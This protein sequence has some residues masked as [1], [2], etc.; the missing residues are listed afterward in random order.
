MQEKIGN[1]IKRGE[2]RPCDTELIAYLLF[3]AYF[4]LVAD[5]GKTHTEDL[6]EE[7]IV[8]VLSE[9]IFKSLLV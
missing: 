8:K 7:R 4:A 1:A 3:K 2:L 5:W 9:T 6:E